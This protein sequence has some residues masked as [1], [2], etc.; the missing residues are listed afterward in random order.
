MVGKATHFVLRNS[1][2]IDFNAHIKIN[3]E[4][5]R[6]P[7]DGL[8]ESNTITNTAARQTEDSVTS[9][10]LVGASG[11]LIRANVITDFVKAQ[12][13][14]ISFGAFAKGGGSNNRFERNVVVCEMRLRGA[15]GWRVGLSLGGGGTGPEFCRDGRCITEQEGSI[16]DSNLIASCSDDGIY[17]NRAAMSQVAHNT[18]MDTGGISVRFAESS[19]DLDGN[20]VDGVVRSRDG[21]AIH[22]SDNLS[23]GLAWLYLGQHPQRALFR[24]ASTLDFT[25]RAGAPRRQANA[26]STTTDLCGAA[27]PP[28]PAYGAFEHFVACIGS[29]Q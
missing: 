6:F 19:A 10:D 13:N 27:R 28:H 2:L 29:G 18:V 4:R 15:A 12:G 11:W 26:V 22:G 25:W 21:A 24:D 9:I 7:D 5:G 3:G 8:I 1:T 23:T 17:L 16:I 14:R 20:L